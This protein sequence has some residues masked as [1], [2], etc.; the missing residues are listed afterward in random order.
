MEKAK[1]EG[2]AE[3]GRKGDRHTERKRGTWSRRR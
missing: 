3:V 2:E 1:G